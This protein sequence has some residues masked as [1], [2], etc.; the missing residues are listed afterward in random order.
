MG[1]CETYGHEMNQAGQK[2]GSPH[3]A[4]AA[5]VGQLLA[6]QPSPSCCS[7]AQIFAVLSVT[8][9]EPVSLSDWGSPAVALVQPQ[10]A[11]TLLDRCSVQI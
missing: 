7:R 1:A 10:S 3:H 11:P 6:H 9:F 8:R 4:L 2:I 5:L